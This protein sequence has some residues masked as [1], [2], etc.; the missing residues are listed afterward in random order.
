VFNLSSVLAQLT[1][2]NKEREGGKRGI[3]R[4][5][6]SKKGKKTKKTSGKK[7]G[8]SSQGFPPLHI[9]CKKKGEEKRGKGKGEK[10]ILLTF[11]PTH[12][13]KGE[14]KRK[15]ISPHSRSYKKG[16]T[17]EKEELPLF[18]PTVPPQEH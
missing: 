4:L 15:R 17:R 7:K 14:K 8:E 3:L 6:P 12:K 11:P 10:W 2:E 9:I 16:K 5:R 18:L 1:R 13:M